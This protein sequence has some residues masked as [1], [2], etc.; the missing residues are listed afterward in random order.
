MRGGTLLLVAALAAG[1]ASTPEDDA[2]PQDDGLLASTAIVNRLA[3]EDGE[4][5]PVG[6]FSRMPTGASAAPGWEPFAVQAGNP[7]TR[8]HTVEVDGIVCMCA[9]AATEGQ[10]A[11]QRLIRIDPRRHPMLEWS[12]R[13]PRPQAGLQAAAAKKP[14]PRARLMLAFHGDAAKLDIEQRIHLRMAKA[15]T[16]TALPYASLVYVWQDGAQPESVSHSPYS[17][18]VRLIALPSGDA[19]L[20]RWQAFR[21]NVLEDYRRA[22]GEDPGEIVGVGIYTDVNSSG[23][24]GLAYY[25]DITFRRAPQTT[26]R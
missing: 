14:S 1:C 25:G 16:G 26:A 23:Q 2:P 24:P 13:V 4:V 18:R 6:R 22:F 12:W 15:I 20:D 9:D 8:Y 11:L 10:S 21:R 19:H 5:I 17:E 3:V 7:R